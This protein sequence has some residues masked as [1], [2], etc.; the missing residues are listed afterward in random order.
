MPFMPV[1]QLVV[2]GVV[3]VPVAGTLLNHIKVLDESL[4]SVARQVTEL[5]LVHESNINK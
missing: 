5:R 4:I 3:K 1:L 2:L